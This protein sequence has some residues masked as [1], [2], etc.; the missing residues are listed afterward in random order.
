MKSADVQQS[1][2]LADTTT[3]KFK[4]I[5]VTLKE[6]LRGGGRLEAS[7]FKGKHARDVL[8]RCKW[9]MITIAGDNGLATSFYPTRFKRILIEESEFPLILPSQIG[10]IDPQPKGYMSHLCDTDFDQLKA[11]KGQILL[12]RSGTVGNC[13]LVM[14]TLHGKTISDDIIRI[15]CN[16]QNNTG[17][18]YAFLRSQIG[19]A[20][21]QSNE[22]GAVVSHIE[23]AHLES[24]PIPDPSNS[25]K[26]QIHDLI[27]RSYTLRDESNVLLEEARRLLLRDL[28][29]SPI[30]KLRPRYFDKGP[31]LRN[32]S[33]NLSNLSGRLDASY[34]VPIVDTILRRLKKDAAEVITLG[35]SRISKRV[36][37][38]GRFARVY[39]REDQGIV[40]FGGKQ[41]L[42]LDPT[43]KKYLSSSHPETR[44]TL[45]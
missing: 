18:L 29:L 7:V 35:D 39:V 9:P 11:Q 22:Y 14:N 40:F 37:L 38:P 17:Y 36:I 44:N 1:I 34:H 10:E 6:V 24:V 30:K 26:K 45:S 33:M 28:N 21:I 42:E 25:I 19:K 8:G 23:P 4:W 41:L 20:L 16:N 12:T 2:E 32:Y 15:K 3:E 5:S 31:G 13:R 43:N 27:L